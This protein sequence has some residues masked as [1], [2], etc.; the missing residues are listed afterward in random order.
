MKTIWRDSN[1]HMVACLVLAG[2]LPV[3]IVAAQDKPKQ[4]TLTIVQK[5]QALIDY[6]AALIAQTKLQAAAQK[7]N[8]TVQGILAEDKAPQGSQI[9]VNPDAADLDHQVI[10]ILPLQTSQSKPEEKKEE[11]K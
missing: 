7:F 2:V 8:Q 1:L 5:Q 4:T 11:K 10:L 3:L 6:Q 9:Q